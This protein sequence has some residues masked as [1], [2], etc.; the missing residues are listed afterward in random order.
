M[1]ELVNVI[2][3]NRRESGSGG[4]FLTKKMRN[5]KVRLTFV[6]MAHLNEPSHSNKEQY[7]INTINIKSVR[8]N[9]DQNE[10][11]GWARGRVDLK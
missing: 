2:N 8:K 1:S 10:P 3:T 5:D 9:S 7:A 6:Y 4:K 11:W